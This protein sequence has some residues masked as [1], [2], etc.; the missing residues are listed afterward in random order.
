MPRARKKN[1]HAKR[2]K[3]LKPRAGPINTC[4]ENDDWGEFT[5]ER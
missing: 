4:V 2:L 1:V 3:Q 5:P